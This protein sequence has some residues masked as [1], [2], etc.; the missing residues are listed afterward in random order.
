MLVISTSAQYDD[1]ISDMVDTCRE[2]QIPQDTE[3]SC[4]DYVR[5]VYE[6]GDTDCF[7]QLILT[8]IAQC[9]DLDLDECEERAIIYA[10]TMDIPIYASQEITYNLRFSLDYF[11]EGNYAYSVGTLRAMT[12]QAPI[13]RTITIIL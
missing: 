2:V 1:Y 11:I 7:E 5:C 13:T 4:D 12:Q 8:L 6:S 9:L 3:E 10:I